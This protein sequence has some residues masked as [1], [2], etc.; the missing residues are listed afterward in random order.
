LIYKIGQK[1]I[2]SVELKS[3]LI[4]KGVSVDKKV[5]QQFGKTNQITA[6]PLMCNRLI[7]LDGT[8]SQL[9]DLSFHMAL[10][11]QMFNWDN[12]KLIKY[13]KDMKTP[14]RIALIDN[15]PI[16]THNGEQVCEVSFPP[17]TD[18]YSQKTSNGLPFIGNSV[19]QGKQWVAFQM[20]WGCDFGKCAKPCQYCFSGKENEARAKRNKPDNNPTP[21]DVREIV[22]YAISN[23]GCDSVQITGGS[24]FDDKKEAQYIREHL[25]AI[26]GLP[27]KEVL[28]YITPPK[29]L[30]LID[31]Y[32]SLG[33]TKI[34]CSLEVW[35]LER[36]KVITPGKIEFT[37]RQ[38]HLDAL[39]YIVKKYGKSKAFSNFI[40]GL[41]SLDTL[42]EGVN[43]LAE[44]GI[45]PTASVWIPFGAPVM[46]SMKTPDIDYFRKVKE[47]FADSYIKYDLE[48]PNG[49]GLNVCIERD[50]YKYAK[51][52][53][54]G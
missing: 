54:N 3:L 29:D 7:L 41:E 26:Q 40:I 20:L 37:G 9:T 19:I 49:E 51:E 17:K 24:T 34:A 27:L 47:M 11:K 22:E 14:F 8:V 46:G 12:M 4:S 30:S 2:D 25:N 1:N 35:D 31:E 5:Y 16:L 33:A 36:A 48:P 39:G 32:F 43:Y 53:S 6:N 18:F 23:A 38:R 42:Q 13:M 50:I 10:I 45:T 52:N 44:R 15:K 21:Q 28:L